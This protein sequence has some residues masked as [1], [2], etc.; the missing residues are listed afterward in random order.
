MSYLQTERIEEYLR[1]IRKLPIV[2][3]EREKEL[4]TMVLSGDLTK[5]QRDEINNEMIEGNLRFVITTAQKF[6]TNSVPIEDLIAEGNYGLLKALDKFDWSAETRFLTYA[7]WW[8]RQSIMDYLN[9]Y[10]RTI[11]LPVNIVQ[12]INKQKKQPLMDDWYHEDKYHSIPRT[13]SL[14]KHFG[15]DEETGTMKDLLINHDCEAPDEFEDQEQILKDKVNEIFSVLDE[16]EQFV[17]KSYYGYLGSP[18]TLQAIGDELGL[19]KERVRQIKEKSLRRLRNESID[20]MI[21]LDDLFG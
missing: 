5:S 9:S 11:R 3:P 7:V 1:D 13:E 15:D 10:S 21:Y 20:L 17:V 2:T 4:K 18:M 19:T 12:E 16:R 14:D 8:I 6:Q